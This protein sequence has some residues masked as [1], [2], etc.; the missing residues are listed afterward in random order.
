M[1][2]DFDKKKNSKYKSKSKSKGKKDKCADICR[3]RW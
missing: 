3:W 2:E 1:T